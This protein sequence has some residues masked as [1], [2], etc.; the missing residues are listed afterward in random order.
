[1]RVAQVPSDA[2][3][4][5]AQENNLCEFLRFSFRRASNS[6]GAALEIPLDAL[7]P[8][9]PDEVWYVHGPV[10]ESFSDGIHWVTGRDHIA[11]YL[12][13]EIDVSAKLATQTHQAYRQ[14]LNAFRA[15][16]DYRIARTWN[17]IPSINAS[18]NGVENY[19]HF[20]TGRAQ[21]YDDLRIK[22]AELPAAT[23]IGGEK[24]SALTII[25]IAS[26]FALEPVENPRQT[27][28]YRY[29]RDYGPDS[30]AFARGMKLYADE[31]QSLIVS[32][33]SS[34]VGHRSIHGGDVVSQCRESVKNILAL[35]ERSHNGASES[36]LALASNGYYRAY[37]RHA[38]DAAAVSS[39]LHECLGC[40]GGLTVLQGD[41]CRRELLVEVEGY[42]PI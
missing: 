22:S 21:A 35:V 4:N 16:P 39:V 40:Q 33:T 7:D 8:E 19:W 20:N 12:R 36:P 15:L 25:V 38:E 34:I 10:D 28:A 2:G 3:S 32:G 9:K 5:G 29:P 24:N 26:R 6:A 13:R 30:P 42:C 1:M 14:L 11:A 17:F 23:A 18:P 31:R 37:V 27:S 41:I